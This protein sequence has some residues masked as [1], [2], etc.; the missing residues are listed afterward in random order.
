M[1]LP[2]LAL[3]RIA[4]LQVVLITLSVG[5]SAQDGLAQAPILPAPPKNTAKAVPGG[6]VLN[7]QGA[8]LTDVL[9]Y[10]SEAAGFVIVQE[11]P[12]SGT[13]NVVSRQAVNAEE[14]VDLLNAV[15]S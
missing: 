1:K 7:F 2:N 13:V 15:L 10:L 9:N 4:V 6:I 12:V 3:P 8:A 5:A 14:A 11:T